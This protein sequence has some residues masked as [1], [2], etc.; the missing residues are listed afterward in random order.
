M[1][2]ISI[3]PGS[4][5]FT[6][7][8]STAFGFYDSDVEFSNDAPNVA[9]W[10][11]QRLGYP[12]V[13]IELQANNLFTA[14][15]EA[16]SE[17]GHQIYTFQIIN[18]LFRIKG[19]STGSSLNQV[20][21]SSD[22]GNNTGNANQGSGLSYN[23]TDQRLYSASLHVKRGQQ[24]Y[25]LISSSPGFATATIDFQGVPSQ[26]ESIS[27]TNTTGLTA[28]FIGFVSSS[29]TESGSIN[30]FETGSSAVQAATNLLNTME[31]GL[32]GLGATLNDMSFSLSGS[33]ITIKQLTEGVGGNTNIISTLSNVTTDGFTGGF[34][35]LN[36]ESSGSQ[37]QA[38][39]TKIKIKKIYHY[40][41]AAI[42]RY[43]DPYAGTGTG[44]QSLMQSFGMGN[45]SP[46]VNFMLMPIYFDALKLQAIEFNDSI[47]KSSYHFELN[48][49]KFL[50]LFPIPTRDYKLWFEYVMADSSVSAATEDQDPDIEKPTNVITNISN[51]P[52]E[53][54]TYSF[55]NEPGRQWIRKYT[56][57]LVK[58]MLGSIRGKYQTIPIPGSDTTLDHARLLAEASAEK[59][60]LI[61]MLRIDLEA[62]TTLKQAERS[63]A[64]SEQTQAQYSVDNPYQIYI[65]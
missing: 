49:G 19:T 54:P 3:W 22:Y 13:D 55:I 8:T 43:F 32:N 38:G 11:M 34:S 17:Y 56:L 14:F 15:E 7:G 33:T 26:S 30:S 31:N 44:I 60:E 36:F 29:N 9:N 52:Y 58:E 63:T 16:V 18:N 20:L 48:S 59:A 51:A 53:R 41:P 28:N 57:A 61:E 10:C 65:H 47:R 62:T 1:A 64:E 27:I 6:A 42:N 23:L 24:K 45:Y 25:N 4:S 12:L 37:I 40:Q 46:G 50:K 35:G 39:T 21:I 2:N 5:S